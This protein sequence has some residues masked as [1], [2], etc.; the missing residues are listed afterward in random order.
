M[1]ELETAELVA[2]IAATWARPEMTVATQRA[3]ERHLRSLDGKFALMAVD[4]L[5][6]TK[7]FLPSIAEIRETTAQ[8]ALGPVRLGMEAW[9][10]VLEAQKKVGFR[11]VTDKDG[12]AASDAPLLQPPWADPLV[13]HCVETMGGWAKFRDTDDFTRKAFCELYDG[14]ARR[15]RTAE[16]AGQ[17][18]AAP[19]GLLPTSQAIPAAVRP[20]P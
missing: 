17:L 11:Q 9:G 18:P 7:T 12:W 1:T 5:A 4:H 2:I 6:A 10:D 3:Y 14:L 16:V 15:E 19:R 8:V 13:A 20:S